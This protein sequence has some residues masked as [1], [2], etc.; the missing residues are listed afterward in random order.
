MRLGYAMTYTGREHR[1]ALVS[2]ARLAEECGWH[3]VW[4]GTPVEMVTAT[5]RALSPASSD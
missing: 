2:H 1:R 4:V 3:G 5:I